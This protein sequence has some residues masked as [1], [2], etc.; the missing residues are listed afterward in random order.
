MLL[1]VSQVE[2]VVPL[3]GHIESLH[4][5]CGVSASSHGAINAILSLEELLVFSL[6]LVYN[7]WG[8]DSTTVTVPIDFLHKQCQ[9][10]SNQPINQD[11]HSLFTYGLLL[12]LEW[13]VI[14]VQN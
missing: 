5:L 8:V 2:H 1:V 11:G 13:L 9:S 10:V 14:V 12:G 7:V 6:D 4:L 3:H